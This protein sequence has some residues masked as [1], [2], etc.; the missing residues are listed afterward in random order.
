MDLMAD[1][2]ILEDQLTTPPEE[3]GSEEDENTNGE[4]KQASGPFG[5]LFPPDPHVWNE[6]RRLVTDKNARVEALATVCAQDPVLV[7]EFLR[8]SNAMY[9][10]GGKS[11]ITSTKTAIVRLGSDMLVATLDKMSEERQPFKDED[12][13]H[14]FEVHRSKCKRAA[15]V[16]RILA[17]PLARSLAD[18]VQTAALFLY[19]G[20]MLAVAHLGH[21]YVELAEEHSRSGVNY[22][23]A[24]DF[25]FDVEKMGLNYLRRAGIPEALL[26]AID[27]DARSRTPDR[28]VMKPICMAA[29]EMIEAF[30][31]NRWEKLAPGKTLSPKSSIRMLQVSDNQYLKIYERASEYLFSARM[32]E[33][34]KRQ[35]ALKPVIEQVSNEEESALETEIQNILSGDDYD[36]ED[37]FE[38]P[39]E[40]SQHNAEHHPPETQI[41]ELDTPLIDEHDQFSLSNTGSHVRKVAR[42][43]E[44]KPIIPP[45]ILRT[46]KGNKVVQSISNM[47]EEAQ[48]SEELLSELLQMLVEDGPFEKSALIVVSK[49]RKSA[50]VVAARGPTFGNGQKIQ[51]DDPLSPL[52]QCFSK[53]Q[54]FGNRSN[55]ASPF[56]SKAFA[57]AP[58]D[59]D[60]DTPVALY[61]DCGQN[62]SLTFEA[63]RVF[64]TVV[65]ILN[66]KLPQIPGG[67]PVELEGSMSH[68]VAED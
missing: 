11:H 32:Q 33:E 40:N 35:E 1:D 23:L 41:T 44:A 59:A 49:D 26:F 63:R 18:D 62:G 6:A 19:I 30:D 47:F 17:E 45:P 39:G 9:Y 64:R 16:G 42:V 12:I 48:S 2:E 61:A 31:S 52:A 38:D 27:R 3:S 43:Q 28:S 15:I 66:E 57:L 34:K 29:A 21:D 68:R 13:R 58:I 65:G 67:I 53:V 51:I 8:I 24:N 60:H 25:R 14:W 55:S 46:S 50:I 4:N 22:K 7:I 36:Y 54:S 56:G 20:D 37:D 10:A 5:I